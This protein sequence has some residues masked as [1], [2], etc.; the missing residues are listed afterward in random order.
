M[1]TLRNLQRT[2]SVI[3]TAPYSRAFFISIG[4]RLIY[5]FVYIERFCIIDLFFISE[6][7]DTHETF[8]IISYCSY[9][10]F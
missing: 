4:K 10:H 1:Q 7:I 5:I 8:F 3:K 6:S 2:K 9:L